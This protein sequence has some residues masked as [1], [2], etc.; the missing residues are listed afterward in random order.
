MENFT[1]DNLEGYLGEI[2]EQSRMKKESQKDAES[3]EGNDTEDKSDDDKE[4]DESSDEEQAVDDQSADEA[5][6]ENNGEQTISKEEKASC[7]KK[8][9]VKIVLDNP[10]D[11]PIDVSMFGS[12]SNAQ[13]FSV[14]N[15]YSVPN[16][17]VA[18]IVV[19]DFIYTAS[20]S[21]LTC[22]NI[23][24]NAKTT[25]IISAS[26]M[27]FANNKIFISTG[28]A[29]GNIYV[30]DVNAN[31]STFN[32]IISTIAL[33]AGFTGAGS[34]ASGVLSGNSIYFTA[35]NSV[36]TN[37]GVIVIDTIANAY[38]TYIVT[39][40]TLPPGVLIPPVFISNTSIATFIGNGNIKIINTT[41]NSISNT[42]AP[43]FSPTEWVSGIALNNILC[44]ADYGGKVQFIDLINNIAI[45]F[46]AIADNLQLMNIGSGLLFVGATSNNVY[47]LDINSKSLFST[48]LIGGS[49]SG[50]C[51]IYTGGG[52]AFIQTSSGVIYAINITYQPDSYLQVIKTINI[53]FAL[54]FGTPQGI[55]SINSNIIN[56]NLFITSYQGHIV[57]ITIPS[58]SPLNA[59]QFNMIQFNPVKPCW[60][61]YICKTHAQMD[62][63]L[64]FN[65][66][67]VLGELKQYSLTPSNILDPMAVAVQVDI[68]NLPSDL[69][70][71]SKQSISH[72]I[73]AH[74]TVILYVYIAEMARNDAALGGPSNYLYSEKENGEYLTW[75]EVMAL[76]D[77]E[78]NSVE[79]ICEEDMCMEISEE[80]SEDDLDE[81][82]ETVK[83]Y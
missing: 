55:A 15:R 22:T 76:E 58:V 32:T 37:L 19:G 71:E 18:S 36:S 21:L 65:Y 34:V 13:I 14:K 23:L 30:I 83:Y 41:L 33:P 8:D 46:V 49:S 78:F 17:S 77:Q 48:I 29:S 69:I 53:G 40:P 43:S 52:L 25:L 1:G 80:D 81:E 5:D 67:N 42:I 59:F 75:E 12:T 3:E 35:Q 38:V 73:N 31:A 28:N 11:L 61:K 2:E 7:S 63:I 57:E 39:Y 56:N 64:S 6:I 62:N 51:N 20:A 16:S 47:V 27:V 24:T 9:Y 4:S 10:T 70:L 72:T 45:S 82:E 50:L 68:V 44:L 66:K 60:I 79:I 74:E 54:I 26:D